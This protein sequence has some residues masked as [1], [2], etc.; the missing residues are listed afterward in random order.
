MAQFQYRPSLNPC[1]RTFCS[2]LGLA[3]GQVN[4]SLPGQEPSIVAIQTSGD[5]FALARRDGQPMLL[6]G[7]C[8]IARAH[9]CGEI[10]GVSVKITNFG[11]I[12]T[13]LVVPDRSGSMAD[14]VLG[15]D[16]VEQYINAVDKPYF[17]A[18]VGRYGN[19]IA[20]GQFKLDG[21]EYKLA[22]NNGPNHLHGGIIGFDKVIWDA[23]PIS[24]NEF[25]G[26]EFSYR[27]KDGEEGYPGNLDVRVTYKLFE[28]NRLAIE[29]DAT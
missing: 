28:N 23:E 4:A 24:G 12:I 13:S 16:R 10:G 22:T 14:I 9:F 11:A 19:R 1:S 27:S 7:I 8:L 26:V 17:G 29:Y 15:Y 18:V 21:V 2:K 3:D 6:G 25:E 5:F 20:Y